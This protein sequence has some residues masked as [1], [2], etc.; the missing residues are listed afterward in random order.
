MENNKVEIGV[1]KAVR[2]GA[3]GYDNVQF[4]LTVDLLVQGCCVNDFLG[5]WAGAPPE[6]AQWTLADQ[7]AHYGKICRRI[8][9]LL[10]DAKVKDLASLVGRP[11]RVY[12][13]PNGLLETWDILKEAVL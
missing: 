6:N 2:F 1:I 9:Q 12:T 7:T 8:H 3:G 13:K 10:T 4:G 11:V 5:C